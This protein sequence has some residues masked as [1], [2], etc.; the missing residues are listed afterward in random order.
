MGEVTEQA[1]ELM[2]ALDA[3]RRMMAERGYVV[4]CVLATGKPRA[5]GD[6]TP[7]FGGRVL[8]ENAQ[9]RV[10]GTTDEADYKQ[11]LRMLFGE[12]FKPNVYEAEEVLAYYRTTLVEAPQ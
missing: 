3:A 2:R 4:I 5:A 10:D 8:Q 12:G 7:F 1:N 11:Q 6:L 9:L